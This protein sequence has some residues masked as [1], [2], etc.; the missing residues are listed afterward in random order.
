MKVNIQFE[1]TDLQS[2]Q[3]IIEQYHSHPYVLY[4]QKRNLT[5]PIPG[6]SESSM[7]S[8]LLMCLLTSQQRSSPGSVIDRFLNLLPFPLSLETCRAV[9]NL[10][11]FAFQ[12]LHDF[13]GIRFAPKISKQISQNF[14][15][16]E[17]GGWKILNDLA[18]NL[19][20]QRLANPDPSHY[21]L[22][23]QAALKTKEILKGIGPKQARNFWQDLGLMR[24]EFVLDS[25]ILKWLKKLNFPIP[26]SSSALSEDDF[27]HFISDIL[28]DLCLQ[29]GVLPCI[30]DAAIFASFDQKY[31]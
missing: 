25:R 31:L 12:I 15:T 7:W 11:A 28:R 19:E 17:S 29:A 22:E 10:Q 2:V 6:H 21:L 1:K 9:E 16:L 20:K 14:N 26:L 3:F 23:R 18:Q 30:L 13:G 4:R 8:V 24:Y 5:E 27:Y